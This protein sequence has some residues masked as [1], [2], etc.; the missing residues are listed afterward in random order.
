MK[1]LVLP[2][3]LALVMVTGASLRAS[4]AMKAIVASYLEIQARLAVDKFEG[5]KPAAEAIGQQATQM[6]TEGAAIVK[7]A[8]AVAD[9]VDLDRARNLRRPQ[10]RGDRGRK[11]GGLERPS[12]SSGRL[13]PD[14]QEV[15]AAKGRRD[16]EPLLRVDDAHLRGDQK[17]T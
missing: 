14:D 13:L 8:K 12:R 10:R 6:G 9:A 15:L 2:V 3:L 16:Q 5:V 7:A 1:K 17:K 4:D 11:R